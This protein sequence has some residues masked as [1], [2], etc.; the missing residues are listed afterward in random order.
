[1]STDDKG[2][3]S[4]TTRDQVS[5]KHYLSTKGNSYLETKRSKLRSPGRAQGGLIYVST[6]TPGTGSCTPDTT[7]SK[8]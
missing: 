6:R 1:M 8:H 4:K 7:M 2:L 5:I 3:G